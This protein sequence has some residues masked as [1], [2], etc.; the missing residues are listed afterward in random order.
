MPTLGDVRLDAGSPGNGYTS[1]FS[2]AEEEATPGYYR[3]FLQDPQV[4]AEL[5]ATA[6]CG[7]HRYTFP[8]ANP[9]NF[10]LDLVHGIA[11]RAV[12]PAS[13]SRTTPRSAARAF[14]RAGAGA[15]PFIL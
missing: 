9:A 11:N 15:A 13:T 4:T 2:H 12:E 10:V 3:V 6:R 7:F 1:R 8:A 14:P 5:T